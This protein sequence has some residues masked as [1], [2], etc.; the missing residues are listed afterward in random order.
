MFGNIGLKRRSKPVASHEIV[1]TD[2]NVLVAYVKSKSDNTLVCAVFDKVRE[3]DTLIVTNQVMWELYHIDIGPKY[4]ATEITHALRRLKPKTVFVV[5]P[6]DYD[7]TRY[8]IDDP[9]DRAILYSAHMANAG[10]ILTNDKAWFRSNVSGLDAIVMDL[11]GYL[12]Q[13]EILSGEKKFDK[14]DAGRIVR[15]HKRGTYE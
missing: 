7:L 9:K 6:T 3:S 13:D 2:T 11:L 1:F 5:N 10:V 4:G 14:P 12:Y 8:T 15:I